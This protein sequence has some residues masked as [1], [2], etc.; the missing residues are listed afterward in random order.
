MKARQ[1]EKNGGYKS[2]V[3][4]DVVRLVTPRT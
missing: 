2:V 3:N 1:G 4:A